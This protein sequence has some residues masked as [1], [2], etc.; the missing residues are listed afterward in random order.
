MKKIIIGFIIGLAVGSLVTVYAAPIANW[1][2][3]NGTAMGT[4][5]NPVWVTIQ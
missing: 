2:A 3:G 1:V 5:S 4:A